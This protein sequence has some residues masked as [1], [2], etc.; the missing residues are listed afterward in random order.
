[1]AESSNGGR[2]WSPGVLPSPLVATPNALAVGPKGEV[3]AVVAD[4]GQR[5]LVAPANLSI[6]RTLTSTMTLKPVTSACDP[7][8]ITAAAFTAVSQPLLGLACAGAG[9]VG[10]LAPLFSTN[11]KQSGWHEI[12]PSLTA[13]DGAP[14]VVRLTSTI[15]GIAGLAEVRTEKRTSLVAFWGQGSLDQWSESVPITVPSGWTLKATATGGGS[16]RG[17][18]V[19]LGSGEQRRV[20]EVAGPGARWASLP[21]APRGAS[22]VA[23]IGLEVDTFVVTNSRL[24]VWKWESGVSQWSE[25]ASISVPIPYGS[26][27]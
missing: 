4:A 10:I 27:S 2:A 20:E 6:W 15:D 1:V 16:G 8:E 5:V 24:A 21:E 19:L 3:L 7:Q 14:A 11:G 17:V 9:E 25:V 26:S 23:E 18:A 12:G 13:S 22:G